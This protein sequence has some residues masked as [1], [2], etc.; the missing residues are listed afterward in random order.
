[1]MK[2]CENPCEQ[3]TDRSLGKKERRRF[4]QVTS[5]AK[6]NE[7]LQNTAA[8]LFFLQLT[9][10]VEIGAQRK[11]HHS[12]METNCFLSKLVATVP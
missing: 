8:F 2:A 1:M 6:F 7:F 9:P 3:G 10:S 4:G 11:A 12:A 5:S